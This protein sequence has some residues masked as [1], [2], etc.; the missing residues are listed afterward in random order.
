MAELEVGHAAAF[1]KRAQLCSE[2]EELRERDLG[3]NDAR[4]SAL[5]HRFDRS[6]AWQL[7]MPVTSP[8]NFSGTTTSSFMIGSR[9]HGLRLLHR[10]LHRVDGGEFEGDFG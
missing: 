7:I 4:L 2:A 10:F 1:G 5:A 9:M 8:M 6:R 3:S